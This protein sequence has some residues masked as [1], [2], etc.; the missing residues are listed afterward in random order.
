MGLQK[1]SNIRRS[2]Q[3]D[4]L[5][6]ISWAE[7]HSADTL[8]RHD[9]RRDDMS[10]GNYTIVSLKNEAS[11]TLDEEPIS[12]YENPD[13]D[14]SSEETADDAEEEQVVCKGLERFCLERDSQSLNSGE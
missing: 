3:A 8:F 1:K 4:D 6:E 7:S 5:S 9:S 10:S 14:N 2:H 12:S 13:S 11:G